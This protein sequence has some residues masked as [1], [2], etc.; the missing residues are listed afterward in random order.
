MAITFLLASVGEAALAGVRRS[1]AGCNGR[2]VGVSV[3]GWRRVAIR[4]D[5]GGIGPRGVLLAVPV[6]YVL[7][8]YF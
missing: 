2:V 6:L 4:I 8:C 7:C 5:V 1:G 3:M